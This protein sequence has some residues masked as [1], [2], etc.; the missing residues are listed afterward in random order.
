MPTASAGIPTSRRA[1]QSRGVRGAPMC[2]ACAMHVQHEQ[3]QALLHVFLAS[4]DGEA[5]WGVC[6]DCTPPSGCACTQHCVA[7]AVTVVL[8]G[9]HCAHSSCLQEHG[10][11]NDAKH[12]PLLAPLHMLMLPQTVHTAHMGTCKMA[13]MARPKPSCVDARHHPW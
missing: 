9:A 13:G 4:R 3:P 8:R 10:C 1:S 6:S 2:S 7:T 5:R 11:S 12:A